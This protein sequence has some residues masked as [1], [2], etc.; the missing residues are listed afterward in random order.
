MEPLEIPAVGTARKIVGYHLDEHFD[1]VAELECGHQQH[2]RHNPPWNVRQW[3]TN[4]QGRHEH[5]GQPL[6]CTACSNPSVK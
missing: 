6:P 1:W 2:V 3:V 4:P 5:L